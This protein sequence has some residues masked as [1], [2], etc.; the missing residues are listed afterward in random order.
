MKYNS[1]QL[2][3][4][5][6]VV[7]EVLMDDE[8]SQVRGFVHV[9]DEEGLTMS[10]L[11]MWSFSDMRSLMNCIQVFFVTVLNQIFAI[12]NFNF[13]NTEINPHASQ[14]NPLHQ[15]AWNCHHIL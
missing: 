10:H 11:S 12:H 15:P 8:E 3:R 5:H 4:L 1:V 13:Q 7:V 9:N 6:S 2:A 14:R